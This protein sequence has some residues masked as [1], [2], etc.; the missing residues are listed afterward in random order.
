MRKSIPLA[1]PLLALVQIAQPFPVFAQSV[2]PEPADS[3]QCDAACEEELAEYELDQVHYG[4]RLPPSEALLNE[5]VLIEPGPK[6]W[7]VVSGGH[8]SKPLSERVIPVTYIDGPEQNTGQ[9]V[10]TII[11]AIPGW[12]QFRRSDARTAN[13]TS[14]GLTSRGLGGNASSRALLTA[15]RSLWRL[16]ELDGL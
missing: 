2:S 6:D 13:P 7:I 11:R 5:I 3:Q 1:L 15:D 4:K 8:L 10:E 12:Q 16:G 14:Q 9:R